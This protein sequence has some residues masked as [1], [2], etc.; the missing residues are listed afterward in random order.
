MSRWMSRRRAAFLMISFPSLESSS[1]YARTLQGFVFAYLATPYMQWPEEQSY[2]IV[3][4]SF[5]YGPLRLYLA[6]PFSYLA[7]VMA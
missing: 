5:S 6:L 7:I 1:S 2:C 3:P 4:A